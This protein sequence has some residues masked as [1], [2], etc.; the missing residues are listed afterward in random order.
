VYLRQQEQ[1]Q[2]PAP[3]IWE[4]IRTCD[5]C[6]PKWTLLSRTDAIIRRQLEKRIGS[7]RDEVQAREY[8]IPS[9]KTLPETI[10][11]W[12]GNIVDALTRPS[13]SPGWFGRAVQ[14]LFNPMPAWAPVQVG[15]ASLFSYDKLINEE[16]LEPEAIVRLC[17]NVRAVRNDKDRLNHA[18]EL[19]KALQ[20]RLDRA[21]DTASNPLDEVITKARENDRV[22]LSQLKPT[23][24]EDAVAFVASFPV[25]SFCQQPALLEMNEDR[26]IF[27]SAAFWQKMREFNNMWRLA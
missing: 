17:D 13:P 25:V 21:R 23:P 24:T 3:L 9:S 1:G 2:E 26:P 6:W 20:I 7:I 12:M 18:N 5:A 10:Q 19:A 14:S 22:D 16:R 8:V 15:P 27:Y 4:H 11:V